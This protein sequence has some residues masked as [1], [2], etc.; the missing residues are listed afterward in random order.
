MKIMKKISI[1]LLVIIALLLLIGFILPS[2]IKVERSRTI[3]APIEMV[4][5]Q[6]NN[7]HLW[8]KWSPWHK[9]DSNMQITYIKNGIG[10]SAAYSWTS[11]HQSVGN[12]TLT[13]NDAEEFKFINTMM[14]FGEQGT[15]TANFTFKPSD[16]GVIVTWDMHSNIGNNPFMRLMGI[17]MKK[18]IANAYDRGL[19]D[20][21]MVCKHLKTIDWYYVDIQTKPAFSYYG[22]TNDKTTMSTM[23]STMQNFYGS[24]FKSLSE[25]N[26]S[27]LG[28]AFAAYY[29][30]GDEFIMEC[31]IPVAD[32]ST[33]L[34]SIES[35]Q[36]P[37]QS[38]AVLTSSGSYNNLENAHNYLDA[39]LKNMDIEMVGPAIEEYVTGPESTDNPEN[40]ITH[41][42]YT[43][44]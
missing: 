18:S 10:K 39:W 16:D 30:W 13:I 25:N 3:D 36:M 19:N 35:K 4:Y 9:I 22:I 31:G 15:G 44:K 6:V 1:G 24:L 42:L 14:D 40:W 29:S 21:D 26:I 5:E 8:E 12:G 37:E 28:P 34:Q 20:I 7:L 32:N 27:P 2:N 11:D 41:I 17:I 33:Q 38:Y 43:I 23:E